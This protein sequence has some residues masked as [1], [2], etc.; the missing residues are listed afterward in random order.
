MVP[1]V[2][3]IREFLATFPFF[4]GSEVVASRD[5]TVV[6]RGRFGG[7]LRLSCL[8]PCHRA[9]KGSGDILLEE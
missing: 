3:P 5:M 4:V 8:L 6:F 2:P 1:K 7:S 9:L